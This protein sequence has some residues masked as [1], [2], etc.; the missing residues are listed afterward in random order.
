M[1]VPSPSRRSSE[2]G[3]AKQRNRASTIALTPA[4]KGPSMWELSSECGKL[5]SLSGST[6]YASRT[7][8]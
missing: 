5:Q 7:G 2:P 4:E 3:D 6:A 8:L 1:R